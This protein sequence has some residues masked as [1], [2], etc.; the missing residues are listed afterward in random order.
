MDGQSVKKYWKTKNAHLHWFWRVLAIGTLG[1]ML[2]MA[3]VA[4]ISRILVGGPGVAEGRLNV[5]A[6]SECSSVM[7]SRVEI[8]GFE[9][10]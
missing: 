5:K 2:V 9:R 7:A 8:T 3:D 1:F 4:E 6:L 10:R